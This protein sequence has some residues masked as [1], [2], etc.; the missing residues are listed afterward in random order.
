MEASQ[1]KPQFAASGPLGDI[2][3]DITATD[4]KMKDFTTTK[5]SITRDINSCTTEYLYFDTRRNEIGKFQNFVIIQNN[6]FCFNSN[7]D[8][9]AAM[10]EWTRQ[11]KNA[12]DADEQHDACFRGASV[13]FSNLKNELRWVLKT[14]GTSSFEVSYL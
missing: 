6:Q 3:F 12:P 5:W 7:N 13:E 8:V 4:K 2:Y 14:I 9:V 10:L 11:S 1:P